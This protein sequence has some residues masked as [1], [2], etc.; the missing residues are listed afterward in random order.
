MSAV[1]LYVLLLVCLAMASAVVH[2]IPT[3]HHA[4][5]GEH[6]KHLF[7]HASRRHQQLYR[8]K[9]GMQAS[10]G[11]LPTQETQYFTTGEIT[12]GTPPQSF[13][14]EVDAFYD[15]ELI[16]IGSNA[17]LTSTNKNVFV[18]IPKKSTYN[19]NNSS[20]YVAVNGN[21]ST[22]GI[23]GHKAQDVLNIGPLSATIKSFAVGDEVP[24]VLQYYPADGILGL[25]PMMKSYENV[26]V[27]ADDLIDQLDKPIISVY[28]NATRRGNGTGQV[29]LGAE[30][31]DNCQST[32]SYVPALNYYRN[33]YPYTVH[34]SSME[35]TIGGQ[36]TTVNL[37]SNVTFYPVNVFDVPVQLEDAFVNG[38]GATY[39][40]SV[41]A[42][43]IDCDTT[44][45]PLITL[46]IGGVGNSTDSTSR[47][48]VLS[49]ADYIRYLKSEDV[50]YLGVTFYRGL[51][52]PA[53]WGLGSQVLNNHCISFN[54]KERTVGFADSKT[55]KTDVTKP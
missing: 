55:P 35:M 1:R 51:I 17:S 38:T 22:W 49:G 11:K 20:T 23:K 25:S 5:S 48:L 52:T 18:D 3:Q 12:V 30:D 46:N 43:T 27:V 40:K 37:D 7:R 21:I 14:V 24:D 15:N 31:N 34:A 6:S 32:W 8:R 13:I 50:C 53:R 36:L 10:V 9:V 39:N 26:S 44:K 28:V 16:L 2:K 41:H 29:T 47:K 42:Y 19:A 54:Y 4:L 45:A 33:S